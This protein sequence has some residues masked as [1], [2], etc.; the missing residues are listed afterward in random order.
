MLCSRP[1]LW[2]RFSK[3]LKKKKLVEAD[4]QQSG[5]WVMRWGQENENAYCLPAPLT[6]FL[7]TVAD[8]VGLRVHELEVGNSG[9]VIKPGD[10]VVVSR[11]PCSLCP[12]RSLPLTY[13]FQSWR[14]EWWWS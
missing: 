9:S 6:C 12:P 11:E 7:F 3:D 10:K 4:Y 13:Y 5:A 8:D 14:S 1:S 2:R